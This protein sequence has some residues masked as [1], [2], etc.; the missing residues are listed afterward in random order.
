MKRFR[1]LVRRKKKA[2]SRRAQ[3]LRN[4]Q[5]LSRAL[6]FLEVSILFVALVFAL[7]GGRASLFAALGGRADIWATAAALAALGLLQ[8]F[9]NERVAAALE[10]R[11][12]PEVYD[13]RRIL[14]DLGQA[15]RASASLDELFNLVVRQIEEALQTSSVA[16]LVRDDPRGDYV[17]RISSARRGGEP[18]AAEPL[19]LPGDAFIVKRLL[20]LSAPLGVNPQEFEAWTRALASAPRQVRKVRQ[21]EIELLQ[22]LNSRLLLQILMRNELVGVISLGPRANGRPFTAEDKQMLTA[23]AGQLAFIIEHSK[24]I[25]RIVEEERLRR[26]LALATEVQQRLFPSSPPATDSLDLSGFCQPARE[27]GGDYFDFLKLDGGEIGLAVADVAG[28]GI[29]AA[30][31]MS[32]V[33]ASLRS[34]AAAQGLVVGN[35]TALADLVR[36][37]N[38]LLWR[39][40]SAASYV[41]FFYAQFDEASRRLTYVNAGHNPPLLLRALN[42][43]DDRPAP[44]AAARAPR[45]RPAPAAVLTAEECFAAGPVWSRL[46]AGGMALGMF[47]GSCYEQEVI[48]LR[49]GDLLFCY[50]DGVTE[51]LNVEGEEFGEARL[52]ALLC[53]FARLPAE[54]VRAAVVERVLAWCRGTP[55]HDD[56]TFVVLKVR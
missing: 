6:L 8:L 10:R 43:G 56:L 38:R 18:R 52:Q 39:S 7:S 55:Q 13:E 25:G 21:R 47:D 41:T 11:L 2:L 33:Q 1:H 45:P 49:P 12:A 4:R 37:M 51:A 53:E 27:V 48:Q 40:T 22:R 5:A 32:I 30:L 44:F 14:F 54:E 16:I 15:A 36:E 28:K 34:L 20:N 46:A 3:A 19:S 50:T 17:C 23:V 26:E 35:K 42:G 9:L 31:L 29:A 24:L